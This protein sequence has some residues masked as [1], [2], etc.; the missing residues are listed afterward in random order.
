M[1]DALAICRSIRINLDHDKTDLKGR[2]HATAKE[3]VYKI[4]DLKKEGWKE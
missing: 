1:K 3:M 2:W 4:L